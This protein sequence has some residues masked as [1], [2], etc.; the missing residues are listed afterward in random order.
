MVEYI[1]AAFLGKMLL[2][3]KGAPFRKGGRDIV[4]VLLEGKVLPFRK[5]GRVYSRGAAFQERCCFLR[6]V[7]E[8]IVEVL[9]LGIIPA[10][11]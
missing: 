3:R 9:L 10:A 4:E 8:Y 1:G 2:F 7:V 11:V 5:G 6:K